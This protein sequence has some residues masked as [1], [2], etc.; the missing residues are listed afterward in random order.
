M[1][2][3][4][5]YAGD[6]SKTVY[7]RLRDSTTGLA[8]T[9]L[10]YNSAGAV[11]SYTLPGAARAAITLAT[12]ASASAAWSSGGF[13][14][15]DDTN[16]K[17][18]YRLD[19]PNAAIASGAYTVISIEFDGIIEESMVIPLHTREV[20]VTQWNGTAVATPD[21]AGFPKVTIKDGTGTGEIALTSGKV[22]EVTTL[23][24]HTAQTGDNYARL[25]APAGASVSADIAAIEAQTDDIG[26]AGAGLTALAQA[27]VCTEARLSELDAATGGKMANQV[28]I[29]Q[30]DTTTDIPGTITT[31]Q[32]T[33]D[34]IETDTQDLQTQVGTAGAGLTNITLANDLSATM[35]TS[36]QT[37]VD[38]AI[39]TAISELGVAAPTA[40]P[41]LRTGL[42]LLYMALRNRLDVQTSGTDSIDVYN[43]AG[44]KIAGKNI[45]DDGSDYSEAQMA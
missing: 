43:N 27:S 15:V 4:G 28:D 37:A 38:A 21:T 42:M 22:D 45:T 2:D 20:N 10:V 35:K 30:T 26:A 1:P 32:G 25:G 24:G 5:I 29:I 39:D 14:L 9:G 44:T 23:T 11:A 16:A 13:I 3:F 36:V 6:T 12:L 19:L 17:G 40:T 7:V 34:A 33:A 41:T 18:L 8:K 31:L